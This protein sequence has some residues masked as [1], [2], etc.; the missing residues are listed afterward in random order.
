MSAANDTQH[1]PESRRLRSISRSLIGAWPKW[2]I[3][4][5]LRILFQRAARIAS[6]AAALASA[7]QPLLG[8]AN[9]ASPLPVDLVQPDGTE[10]VLHIRGDEYFNWL[11][12]LQGYTVVI[13]Q[14]RYVYANLDTQGL[15]A[16]TGVV[17]GQADPNTAGLTRKTLPS[18]ETLDRLRAQALPSSPQS[19]GGGGAGILPQGSVKNLVILCKFSDHV[20]GTHTRDRAD[21]DVLFNAVGGHPVLAPTGSVKDY[22]FETSYGA[23]TLNSTV[24]AW[25]TLP[26]TE[27]FYANGTHGREGNFPNNVQ[28]MARDALN[29]VDPL[30]NFADFDTDNDGFVDAIDF[31]HSGY[32]AD[33]GGGGGNWI[34]SLRWSLY[35][36][37]GGRWASADRNA[38]G[39][40][41]KVF[42]FHTEAA[43]WGTSGN[44]IVRI[45]VICHETGH[46][47]GLP[48]LYDTDFS[49]EGIGSYCLMANSW[50]FDFTQLH[51]PHFSAWCKTQLGWL[52]PTVIGPGNY[53]APQVETGPTAFRVDAGYPGGEYLLIENRQKAGFENNMPQGG[54]A[55]WHID[56]AKADNKDEGYPGQAGWPGNN[57]HLKVALLQADGKYDLEHHVNRGDGGDVFHGG[58]VNAIGADTVPNTHAYQNGNI[59]VT[60]NRISAISASGPN[61]TFTYSR[62]TAAAPSI[63]NF[64]PPS[65]PVGTNV[66][67]AGANFTG[68]TA[69]RF[70]GISAGF[71]VNSAVQITATVPP[72]ATTGPITVT[73]AGGTA[74]SGTSFTVIASPPANDSFANAQV[75]SGGSGNVNANN[76]VATKEAGEPNH[77]GNPG[78][79]S[80]WYVWTAPGGGPVTIDTIGSGFNTLLG[81]YTG[82]SLGALNLIA[83][84]DDTTTNTQSRVS[85]TALAGTAYRIAVDGFNG[86]SGNVALHWR[87]SGGGNDDFANGQVISG[88][89]GSVNANNA[90][91]TK[92]AGEPNHA[93]NIGGKSV[94]YFWT[95]PSS[96]QAT[97]DTMNSSFDTLLGVYTGSNVEALSLLAS[98]DDIFG[99]ITTQSQVNLPVSAGIT[100]RIAVD[101]FDGGSGNVV[102]N[103]A[104]STN[105]PSISGFAPTTGQAGTNV[106]VSGTNFA[107]ATAVRFNGTSASFTVNNNSQITATV[108]VGATTGPISVTT[109]GGTATS[110]GNFT[111]SSGFNDNFA[112]AQGIEG[113]FGSFNGSTVGATKEAGEPN[114]AGNVGARSIWYSWTALHSGL[115]TFDTIGSGFDT[116]LGVYTG[117]N[118]GTLSLIASNDDIVQGVNQQSFVSFLTVAGTTYRIAVDGFDGA[119]GNVILNWT[120]RPLNDNFA[121]GLILNGSAGTATRTSIG[122]TK[123]PGEP[124]HAGN[125]GGRSVWYY[126]TA[127]NHGSVVIDTAGS[128]F[129]TVMAAYVGNNVGAL[130][131]TAFNDDSGGVTSQVSF[132]VLAGTTYRIAVDG[133]NGA[134]GT[135]VINWNFILSSD[136]FANGYVISGNIGSITG[137]NAGSTKEFGEPNH[138]GNFGGRSIWTYWTAPSS[139]Q[140]TFNT[141]G[142]SFDT[143]L[144]VYTGNSV[145]ALTPIASNDDII[146]GVNPWSRVVFAAAAGTVYRIAVDG[147]DAAF[148][149]VVLNWAPTPGNDNF[150]NGQVISGSVGAVNGTNLGATKEANEPDHAANPGRNS[151][152]YFW[153]APSSAAVAIDT[154]GSGF[155]TLLAVYA[156]GNV[157]ALTPVAANDDTATNA[158]SR[159][160]FSAAAGT[161]YRIA[162]DGFNGARGSVVLNWAV[163]GATAPPPLTSA[164]YGNQIVLSWPDSFAG[165]NLESTLALT[166]GAP[167]SA[168][169]PLPVIVN[170]NHT[171]SNTTSGTSRFYRL[172][173]P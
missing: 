86:A 76:T 5:S 126:W 172:R 84:N 9:I 94:W 151:I 63:S 67:I 159:V 30:V 14:G 89:I 53:S 114:H 40:N 113:S 149:N 66:V 143:L 118:V 97:I 77:A 70:N 120:V 139:G 55:I 60:S 93:G 135:V 152:W 103:W 153:T 61:M 27:A 170:G 29:L 42:D 112:N 127:P 90:A 78:G 35:Q 121:N 16:P 7:M 49:S 136:N 141:E 80:I 99:G 22:Y 8:E 168:V 54:L 129:D 156:G 75:I 173:K 43:L 138:A 98:N 107:G 142:S 166:S 74:T 131:L 167:W 144:A 6:G 48:D 52:T 108:P 145:G 23:M 140:F 19:A 32:A 37:A 105:L 104:L 44:E 65:G 41:V 137:N 71:T 155:D 64:N 161:T 10:I 46:F 11:E 36:V 57:R 154:Q 164:R 92:E 18:P 123:E 124:N 39:V 111:V 81:V 148:G 158:Q 134:F 110:L 79:K 115:V 15:L 2:D 116:L 150:A 85:F 83:N 157:G 171:V 58:G 68:A 101:G 33:S 119:F 109:P 88:S 122:A 38:N 3:R 1:I 12:D 96:G 34:W 106:V 163:A 117:N 91:A 59:I 28:G 125:V 82:S 73:T 165:F 132:P 50:G 25:V 160:S 169:S 47:F 147:F 26:Q 56:E 146:Q 24:V 13:N 95:P 51:P 100:Y 21:Y 69:V 72:G 162:V 4:R 45:G 17:V 130:T 31:I 62:A 133:F 87:L 128:S 102:L 20:F